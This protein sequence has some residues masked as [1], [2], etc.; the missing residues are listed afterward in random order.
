MRCQRKRRML[1]NQKHVS[2]WQWSNRWRIH[3]FVRI[4]VRSLMASGK[5]DC[6]IGYSSTALRRI[7]GRHIQGSSKQC[8]TLENE[9]TKILRNVSNHIANATTSLPERLERSAN[10][11]RA[12]MFVWISV[13]IC[14]LHNRHTGSPRPALNFYHG[15]ISSATLLKGASESALFAPLWNSRK[16]YNRS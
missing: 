10:L 12:L 14:C 5:W 4:Q 8:W 3:F 7:A 1:T 13:T 2:K 6:V 11:K 15:Q 9:G 16:M